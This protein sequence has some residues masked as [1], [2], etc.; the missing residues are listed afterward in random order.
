[1]RFV[2]IL[3]ACVLYPAPLRD[4]LLRLAITGLFA[5]RWTDRIHDEWISNLV[6]ARPELND[7]LARTRQLMN[8]AVPDA[9]VTGYEPLIGALELPDPDDQHVFAAAI[10][11][12]AQA[13]ITFNTRDFPAATLEPYGMEALH[14]DE[15]LQHQLGLNQGIVINTARLHRA[16][17]KNPPKETADYLDTL[18]AQGLVV[19]ADLLRDFEELI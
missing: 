11:S 2:V 18:S 15:F 14:P 8:D 10:R 3:D 6:A 1:M 5:A 17:L 12:N 7:K 13:I 19:T 4:F 9:L 16:S